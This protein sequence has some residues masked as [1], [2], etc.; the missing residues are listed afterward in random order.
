MRIMKLIEGRSYTYE[1]ILRKPDLSPIGYIP[2]SNLTYTRKFN[3]YDELS[4]TTFK[5]LFNQKAKAQYLN[6]VWENIVAGY[7]VELRIWDSN[8]APESEIVDGTVTD[9]IKTCIFREYFSVSSPN[10]PLDEN[11]DTNKV[12]SCVAQHQMRFKKIK[13]RGFND[14]RKLF[15]CQLTATQTASGIT[16]T[17]DV[18]SNG[19]PIENT[20]V[21]SGETTAF[22]PDDNT[23][24]GIMDYILQYLLP[25]WQITYYDEN[26]L[27][28]G[29]EGRQIVVSQD[30]FTGTVVISGDDTDGHGELTQGLATYWTTTGA[31]LRSNMQTGIIGNS[32]LY[33]AVDGTEK[34]QYAIN[35]LWNKF[36]QIELKI[37]NIVWT[38]QTAIN[39]IIAEPLQGNLLLSQAENLLVEAQNLLQD[40]HGFNYNLSVLNVS[41]I[42]EA[43][44]FVYGTQY[45][46]ALLYKMIIPLY[47]YKTA[48][49]NVPYRNLSLEGTLSDVFEKLE[50]AFLC[51]FKFD[52]VNKT[53]QIYSRDNEVVNPD[54]T[55]II[56]P[57]NYAT[58]VSYQANTDQ[59]MTR[60][61]LTGKDNLWITG[62]N[63]TGERFIDDFSYFTAFPSKYFTAVNGTYPLVEALQDYQEV[64]DYYQDPDNQVIPV[65]IYYVNST[66]TAYNTKT[67]NYT[68][69]SIRNEITRLSG[70]VSIVQGLAK[71]YAY[72]YYSSNA[73]TH[74]TQGVPAGAIMAA[75]TEM[76]E[77]VSEA[78]QYIDFELSPT[79][80]NA[81]YDI[82][83]DTFVS[84][85]TANQ[86]IGGSSG[87]YMIA[88]LQNCE[89]ALTNWQKQFKYEN[90]E[91]LQGNP[92]F[93]T[94]LL[95]QLQEY[96]YE[97][98][99]TFENISD[100][101]ILYQYGQDYLSYINRIP[102]TIDIG[103]IDILSNYKYQLD[104]DKITDVG[105]NIRIALQDYD[106]SMH[107]TS[108][109]LMSYTHS[110]S[111][112]NQSLSITM[113][114]TYELQGAYNQIMQNV[115]YMSY[116]NAKD[117]Q[118]YKQSWEDYIQ[119]Q[120]D[121]ILRGQAIAADVNNIVDGIGNT[122]IDANGLSTSKSPQNGLKHNA[123]GYYARDKSYASTKNG[124]GYTAN[125]KIYPDNIVFNNGDFTVT[126]ET[127]GS[128]KLVIG[129]GSSGSS[130]YDDLTNKPQINGITLS[131]NKTGQELGLVG[132][133]AASAFGAVKI[134]D[135]AITAADIEAGYNV[136]VAYD[137]TDTPYIPNSGG[138]DIF[139]VTSDNA[140]HGIFV[141]RETP[142]PPVPIPTN[143]TLVCV[144][145]TT[146][147][148]GYDTY[149]NSEMQFAVGEAGSYDSYWGVVDPSTV[150]DTSLWDWHL[151]NPYDIPNVSLDQSGKLTIG[152]LSSIYVDGYVEVYATLK[153]DS[154]ITTDIY[155]RVS[156]YTLDQTLT[157]MNY[158]INS[159]MSPTP[160]AQ[161]TGDVS[162]G[163]AVIDTTDPYKPYPTPVTWEVYLKDIND[164]VVSVPSG[165]VYFYP[166]YSNIIVVDYSKFDST[167]NG[168]T[169]W[170][171]GTSTFSPSVSC[172]GCIGTL[173]IS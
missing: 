88:N 58:N 158:G 138:L 96:I 112:D 83:T 146:T 34:D 91:D 18:D 56:S 55:L 62:A 125:D 140:G 147:P 60:A 11:S 31:T 87:F 65:T 76:D 5:Y 102:V 141:K 70:Y 145:G 43:D 161:I 74:S 160:P 115:W 86:P 93:T 135:H 54:S 67:V 155:F 110:I 45:C 127:D 97:E 6:P 79:T 153:T 122:V 118:N 38:N 149:P 143:P 151:N 77:L 159:G 27:T 133:G 165:A 46:T 169:V 4:L 113:S 137:P 172:T 89:T 22:V 44:A 100:D 105:A 16:Y 78:S 136:Y 28:I 95:A 117:I 82:Q 1:A 25:D 164:N 39:E 75:S 66:K 154:T 23:K 2:Y 150:T 98:D 40:L 166:Y 71:Q 84:S 139:Q 162:Y 99:V 129:S 121:L 94:D 48:S 35:A 163:L 10:I 170:F 29:Q 103:M 80:V 142:T 37:N 132:G 171:K 104:W 15:D 85:A 9:S 130:S 61:Y 106:I 20:Y 50:D 52:N 7:I 32:G 157:S 30:F 53:I 42:E 13:L 173:S 51:I 156:F 17:V 144:S 116:K 64:K 14:V 19:Y 73:S 128:K 168:Y 126:T 152:N 107:D 111:N 134:V 3:D 57:D 119:K 26:L 33:G 109:K 24:G 63:I 90:V 41:S 148:N 123:D 120:N 47:I 124:T 49:G 72:S 131:G 69:E 108:F 114:N 92:I 8:Y 36:A 12:I 81:I 101:A 21:V 59:I 68:L 167:Y